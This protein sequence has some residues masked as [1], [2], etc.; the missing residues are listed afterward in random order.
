[1]WHYECSN[2]QCVRQ[3]IFEDTVEPMGLQHCRSTCN[4]TVGAVDIWPLPTGTIQTSSAE[5]HW[6][7]INSNA[8]QFRAVNVNS[9][10]DFW[11]VNQQRFL[12]QIRAKMPNDSLPLGNAEAYAVQIDIVVESN[13]V[14]LYIQVDEAYTLSVNLADGAIVARIESTTIFGARHALES[15]AQLFIYDDVT[16]R[17]LVRHEITFSDAPVYRHRGASLDTARNFFSVDSIK[18]LIGKWK[19]QS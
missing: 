8:V 7:Q 11:E 3:R 19:S 10:N 18:R 9:G 13:D 2:A 12:R 16:D 15:L 5:I 6:S 14:K 17:L 1:M 4:F